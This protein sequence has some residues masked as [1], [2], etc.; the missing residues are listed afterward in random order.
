MQVLE[1]LGAAEKAERDFETPAPTATGQ[2]R[3]ATGVVATRSK[4]ERL[5][6]ST[7]ESDAVK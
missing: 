6:R 7:D 4:K 2:K 3:P 5:G 1:R